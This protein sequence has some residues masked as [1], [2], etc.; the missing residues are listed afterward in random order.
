LIRLIVSDV[1]GTLLKDGCRSPSDLLTEQIKRL[2]RRGVFFC[3]ASG[4]SYASLRTLFD[5]AADDIIFIA[6]DGA[7]VLRQEKPVFSSPISLAE[8]TSLLSC[9]AEFS[10]RCVFSTRYYE[11]LYGF[12]PVGQLPIREAYSGQVR[13][14]DR[15]TDVTG[16]YKIGLYQPDA[17][18]R[19]AIKARLSGLRVS[20]ED[21]N[22]LELSPADI[23]KGKALT[24]LMNRLGIT[25]SQVLAFGDNYNDISM[26][27]N[28]GTAYRMEPGHY[29]LSAVTPNVSTSVEETVKK[30][31]FRFDRQKPNQR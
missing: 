24:R 17:E 4:R 7:L 20:Y 11:G 29:D 31:F 12:S 3:A 15:L 18:V 1:D 25:R 10:S 9:L 26:L 21:E 23:D 16:V 28:A 6:D 2:R 22:W 30:L 8:Q 5:D 14:L 19:R 13:T 27:Q